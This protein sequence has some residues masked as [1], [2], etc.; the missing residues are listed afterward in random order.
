MNGIHQVLAYAN[1]G[2]YIGTINRKVDVL[3]NIC[4]DICLAVNTGET[5]YME[6]GRHQG[7]IAN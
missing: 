2:D 1:D 5:N 3:L 7:M 6:I 4:K